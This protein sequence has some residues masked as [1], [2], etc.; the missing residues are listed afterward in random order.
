MCVKVSVIT[1]VYNNADSILQC[2]ES[3]KNQSYSHIE[4]I[5]IDGASTD[6]TQEIIENNK[7]RLDCYH[8]EE[9][10]GMYDAL[11]KG[12][13]RA[14]G[15]IIGVLHADDIFYEDDTIQ[16]IVDSFQ[17]SDADLVYANGIYV[18]KSDAEKFKR[19]YKSR[20]FQ[21]RYL[22]WGWVPLH[23]TIFVQ[24]DLFEK[25]GYYSTDYKIAGDYEI[26]LRWFMN[27]NIKKYFLDTWVVK[28]RMGGKST[29][30]DLQIKKSSEDLK[31]IREYELMGYLTLACK[32]GRK[33]PQYLMPRINSYL[34]AR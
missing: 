14:T 30:W 31:I 32:I 13:Q 20:T 33:I 1:I 27:N 3:V 21:K 22:K 4:H 10:S 5:V 25:Y 23:T 2:L 29:T 28:M 34:K 17:K 6:G 18:D 26:S 11:N 9:D 24:K 15:D 12:I 7:D 19:F 16:I 8:S